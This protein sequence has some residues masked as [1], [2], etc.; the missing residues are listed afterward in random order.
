MTGW[1]QLVH[2]VPGRSRLRLGSG[3]SQAGRDLGAA[4]AGEGGVREVRVRELTGSMLC[5]H[6]EALRPQRILDAA[7]GHGWTVLDAGVPLPQPERPL[8]TSSIA[9]EL[10]R[11]FR[12]L[13]AEVLRQ[14]DGAADVG[15]LLTLG[16]FGAGAVDVVRTGCIPAPP[17]FNLAWWGFRTFMTLEREA[18]AEVR[19]GWLASGMRAADGGRHGTEPDRDGNTEPGSP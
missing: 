18:I 7:R 17:W 9:R 19:D 4:L 16:F 3:D 11:L 12:E 1:V 14:T 2:A 13:N 15:M 6:D 5:L 8:G 10:A